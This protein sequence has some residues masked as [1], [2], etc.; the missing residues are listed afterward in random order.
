MLKSFNQEKNTNVTT[1]ASP[2]ADSLCLGSRAGIILGDAENCAMTQLK[3]KQE[4][5][6]ML[7]E[8]FNTADSSGDGLIHDFPGSENGGLII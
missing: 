1:G 8:I 4:S 5:A 2:V 3:H 6:K 7:K